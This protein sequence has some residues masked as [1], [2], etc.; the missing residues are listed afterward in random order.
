MSEFVNL[1]R[2]IE[3]FT[4]NFVNID[5]EIISFTLSGLVEESYACKFL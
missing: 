1:F 2:V 3:L 5:T 4:R